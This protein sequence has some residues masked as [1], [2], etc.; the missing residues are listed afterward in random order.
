MDLKPHEVERLRRSAV[1]AAPNTSSG[2]SAGQ[3]TAILTQLAEV[4]LERDR[5]LNELNEAGLS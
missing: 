3:A 5:L 2:L 4:T 1:I